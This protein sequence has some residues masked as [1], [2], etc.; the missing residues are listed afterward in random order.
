MSSSDS[1]TR[2]STDWSRSDALLSQ[3]H[4]ILA[5]VIHEK[6]I[7]TMLWKLLGLQRMLDTLFDDGWICL[8]LPEESTCDETLTHELLQ[9]V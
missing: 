6:E 9:A 3:P 1:G 5:V 2:A 7:S 8:G 4:P